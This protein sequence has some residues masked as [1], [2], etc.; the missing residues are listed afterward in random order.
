MTAFRTFAL[1]GLAALTFA[2]PSAA[3]DLSNP[4][5]AFPDQMP[6]QAWLSKVE[7][8]EKGHR[9]GNPEAEAELIEFISYTC[10]H[11][12]DFVKQ[13]DGIM[14]VAAIGPGHISVEVRPVIRNPIDLVVT[15]LVHCGDISTFKARHRAFL[16]SQ[17]RWFAKAI[18]SPRSQ[19]EIWSRGG[20]A[21]RINAA[22][23]LDLDDIVLSKGLTLPQIN[24][25]LSDEA[26][27][28]TILANDEADRKVFGIT[29]TPTFALDGETL[30]TASDWPS[31]AVV[32]QERFRPKPQESVTDG[33]SGG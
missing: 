12:A 13:S 9:I 10:G 31:L 6:R 21:S 32:L 20:A 30:E 4:E 24:T 1:A 22:K 17:D 16:Y 23:A 29:G 2:G 5:S 25:C 11:C 18:Q 26:M 15:M 14:D 3:Q 27:A 19:Q 8:T 7:R 33:K 28:Q